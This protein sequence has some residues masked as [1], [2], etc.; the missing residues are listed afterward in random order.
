MTGRRWCE[1]AIVVIVRSDHRR[2]L[3]NPAEQ[4]SH[5]G[6][7]ELADVFMEHEGDGAQLEQVLHGMAADLLDRGMVDEAWKTLLAFNAG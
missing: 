6:L 3:V 4:A 7:V 1:K 5:R 2:S